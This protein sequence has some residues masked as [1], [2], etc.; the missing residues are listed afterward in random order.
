MAT[1]SFICKQTED[2]RM[3]GIYCH[4]D[5]Y[6][7]H[8]GEILINSYADENKIN[9]LLMLGDISSLGERVVPPAGEFHSYDNPVE[10][11]TIAYHRDRKDTLNPPRFLTYADAKGCWA[12]YI[13]VYCRDGKWRYIN[14]ALGNEIQDIPDYGDYYAKTVEQAEGTTNEQIPFEKIFYNS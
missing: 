9:A 8:H 7:L 6:P 13:Y 11:V 10:G 2:G 4:W 12:E 1:R 14:V 3:F 5:G